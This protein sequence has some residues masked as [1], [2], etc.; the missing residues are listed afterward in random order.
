MSKPAWTRLR[1]Y[2]NNNPG[3]L[4]ILPAPQKW[5]GQTGTDLDPG[6][7]FAIFVSQTMGWRALG[8]CLLTYYDKHGLNTVETICNRWAPL[9]DGNDTTAYAGQVSGYMEVD[10]TAV[11]DM[12]DADT[13]RTLATGIA[14]CEGGASIQWDEDEKELGLALALGGAP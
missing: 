1:P 10:P 12:H 9:E 3:D 8:V 13:L 4:R 7:P 6:G 11:I 2:R 14:L 5:D